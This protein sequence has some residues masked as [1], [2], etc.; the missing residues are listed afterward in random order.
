[1][2]T[3]LQSYFSKKLQ[4]LTADS[5][6]EHALWTHFWVV[7][8]LK[9]L[10]SA[11]RFSEEVLSFYSELLTKSQCAD[12]GLSRYHNSPSVSHLGCTFAGTMLVKLLDLKAFQTDDFARN[13][14]RS[15]AQLLDG[16]KLRIQKFGESDPRA[17][18]LALAV[19][20]VLQTFLSVP[21]IET[22]LRSLRPVVEALAALE[23]ETGGFGAAPGTES[24]A[25]YT[26]CAVSAFRLFSELAQSFG[27]PPVEQKE[28]RL[29]K[30]LEKRQNADGGLNGRDGKRSDTCYSFWVL[31][32][33]N[34]G[35]IDREKL[36]HFIYTCFDENKNGFG[37]HCDSEADLYHTYYSLAALTLLGK[38]NRV[39]KLICIPLYVFD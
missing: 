36:E 13:I 27:L 39:G 18:Y 10:D 32:V 33:D 22:A 19:L 37:K 16:N 21:E 1:M 28:T 11:H 29:A 26:Y 12:G 4:K 3:K 14:C 31:A 7:S 23:A 38:H 20:Y 8:G 2:E 15:V 6:A 9:I 30:W 25:G 35:E 17:V 24:H 34:C 5:T